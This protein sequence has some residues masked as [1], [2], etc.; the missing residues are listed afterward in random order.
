MLQPEIVRF[1]LGISVAIF[2]QD[3]ARPHIAKTVRNF[4]SA[5]RM[6]HLPWPAYS[7]DISPIE[8]VWDLVDRRLA[9]DP[10]PAAS[11]DDLWLRIQAKRSSLLQADIQKLFESIPRHI[12]ALIAAHGG[13]TKY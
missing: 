13:Y 4:C 1:F 11:K 7:P 9:R 8:Q 10:P 12:T 3:N 5:Q 2:Q 6:Q